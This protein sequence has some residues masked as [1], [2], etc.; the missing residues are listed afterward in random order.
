MVSKRCCG[1]HAAEKTC[2]TSTRCFFW[3]EAWF[4]FG[5]AK[6]IYMLFHGERH[7]SLVKGMSFKWGKICWFFILEVYRN[8]NIESN[9]S[10]AV[11]QQKHQWFNLHPP[12]IIKFPDTQNGHIQYRSMGLVD[13]TLQFQVVFC[14]IYAAQCSIHGILWHHICFRM[15]LGKQIRSLKSRVFL[16]IG[17]QLVSGGEV[18][19]MEI[20]NRNFSNNQRANDVDR[21]QQRYQK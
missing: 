21:L 4:F 10:T 12:W 16:F 15:A 5:G 9:F 11:V 8:R 2:W 13:F 19:M 18:E 6:S 17:S 1:F 7:I 3:G 20:P 14:R